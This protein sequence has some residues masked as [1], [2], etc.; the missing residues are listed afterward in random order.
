MAKR[1]KKAGITG[2]YGTRYGGAIRRIVKKFELQ[3]RAKYVCPACGKVHHHL[4]SLNSKE[5][6]LASGAVEH[7]KSLLQEELTSSPLALQ[8]L[9]KSL[10]TVSKNSKKS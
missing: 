6:L 4:L 10:W 7:A 2:K 1:T 3:Q 8:P 5:L 9:P